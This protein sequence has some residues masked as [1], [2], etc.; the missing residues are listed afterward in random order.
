MQMLSERFEISERMD[1]TGSAGNLT[2]TVR[3]S[4]VFSAN[5]VSEV[6]SV[7]TMEGRGSS[8]VSDE[9]GD[10]SVSECGRGRGSYFSEG[11][12]YAAFAGDD[13]ISSS[14][15]SSSSSLA[16]S[17]GISNH[18]TTNSTTINPTTSHSSSSGLR[19]DTRLDR[20]RDPS[21]IEE[22]HISM[23]FQ[24]SK[25]TGGRRNQQRWV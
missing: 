24:V 13:C 5:P 2:G 18:H 8:S 23:Y 12:S 4:P 17:G 15:A 3:P 6:L 21:P 9:R 16:G 25:T 14:S 1:L 19:L 10:N 11:L 7:F 22:H 20:L